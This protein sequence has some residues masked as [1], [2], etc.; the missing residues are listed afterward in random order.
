MV[1]IVI[2][3]VIYSGNMIR[4][5]KSKINNNESVEIKKG[6]EKFNEMD[7]GLW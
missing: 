2:V 3:L 5:E 7:N 4:I 1:V 6:F